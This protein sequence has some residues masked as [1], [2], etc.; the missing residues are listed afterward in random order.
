MCCLL[1]LSLMIG[2]ITDSFIDCGKWPW[3]TIDD[4]SVD[5]NSESIESLPGHYC[6][7]CFCD[8][9]ISHYPAITVVHVSVAGS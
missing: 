9:I 7:S 6:G 2:T 1:F 4:T 5:I 3:T 8:G